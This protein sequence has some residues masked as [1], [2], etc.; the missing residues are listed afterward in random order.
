LVPFRHAPPDS[1]ADFDCRDGLLCAEKHFDEIVAL[2]YSDKR[3]VYCT[4]FGTG[5]A[6]GGFQG[7]FNKLEVCYDPKKLVKNTTKAK[8]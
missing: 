4:K 8:L 5:G 7:P 1:D 2:G 6:N 3:K